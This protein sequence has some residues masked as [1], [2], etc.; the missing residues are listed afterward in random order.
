MFE[1]DDEEDTVKPKRDPLWGVKNK[2]GG[3]WTT[4]RY[5]GFIRSGLRRMSS[6]YPVKAQV[7]AAAKRKYNGEDKR[8]R[9]EYQCA[10]C[11]GWFPDK[12][13]CVDHIK[14]CGK[15]KDYSDLPEFVATLF[16]EADNLQVLC[17]TCHKIK[18]DKERG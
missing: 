13:V 11:E 9:F 1:E 15:L 17:D 8:R 4:A 14:P 5:F 3:V 6:R 10:E 16:C 18:T 2:A 7:K 12:E